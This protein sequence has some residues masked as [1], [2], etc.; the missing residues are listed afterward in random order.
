MIDSRAVH[1][2]AMPAAS[3]IERQAPGANY[4]DAYRVAVPPGRFRNIEDVIAV[5]FQKGHEVGRSA[6]EVV[7]HGC[8]PGLTWAVA[9]QLVAG[10]EMSMLT[11]SGHFTADSSP[12]WSAG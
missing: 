7:Y 4:L 8:A 3:L 10:G 9:Y 12:S 11:V 6:T 5:A 2:V 1:A